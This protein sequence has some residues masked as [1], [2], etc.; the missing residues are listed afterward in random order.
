MPVLSNVL[1][2][3]IIQYAEATN[4]DLIARIGIGAGGRLPVR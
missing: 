4:A 1:D 3:K 2:D